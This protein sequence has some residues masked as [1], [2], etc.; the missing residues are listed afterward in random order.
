VKLLLDENL[1][2]SHVR[3]LR[4]AGHDAVSVVEIGLAG[5]EDLQVQ[6]A[7]MLE[8]RILVTLD[9]DF[10]NVLRFPPSATPGVIRLRLHPPTETA[11]AALLQWAIPRLEQVALAGR[12]A[13]VA[14]SRIRIRG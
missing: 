7:A 3:L 14:G 5:A 6:A 2:P 9:A 13:V 11:I 1:A 12:L 10:A 4:A 8:N